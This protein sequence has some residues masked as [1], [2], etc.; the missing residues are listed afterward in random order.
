MPRLQ[1]EMRSILPS[2]FRAAGNPSAVSPVIAHYGDDDPL[3]AEHMTTAF[4]PPPMG[5]RIRPPK[6]SAMNSR[7]PKQMVSPREKPSHNKH[8][9]PM[10]TM[11]TND[12]TIRTSRGKECCKSPNL[13]HK[14]S[15]FFALARF[16]VLKIA[17]SYSK[18]VF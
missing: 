18:M 9:P 16:T 11:S 8:S 1:G 6:R 3:R 10:A 14:L 4:E 13:A 15:V 7:L 12:G 5:E 17:R 2:P